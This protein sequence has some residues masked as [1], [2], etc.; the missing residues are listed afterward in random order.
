MK[1]AIRT[2]LMYQR[3]SRRSTFVPVLAACWVMALIGLGSGPML[4]F[5]LVALTALG[6]VIFGLLA[7]RRRSSGVGRVPTVRTLP[8]NVARP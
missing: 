4:A 8:R 6:L 7:L 1:A 5:N 3:R 2:P